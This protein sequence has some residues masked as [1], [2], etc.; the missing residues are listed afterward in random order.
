ML[1]SVGIASKYVPT[2]LAAEV[3]DSESAACQDGWVAMPLVENHVVLL[4]AKL[5][6][7]LPDRF[8]AAMANA[9]VTVQHRR[10]RTR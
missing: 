1:T 5:E 10:S 4:K 9:F 7:E 8:Q 3:L 2:D 6:Q